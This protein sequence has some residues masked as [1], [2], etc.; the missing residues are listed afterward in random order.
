MNDSTRLGSA[1]ASADLGVDSAREGPTQRPESLSIQIHTRYNSH[2]G[3]MALAGPCGRAWGWS[4]LSEQR[5]PNRCVRE[6]HLNTIKHESDSF[7]SEA[8]H[9]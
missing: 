9:K 8:D 4:D 5:C 6:S 7:L 2:Y 1:W 3:G